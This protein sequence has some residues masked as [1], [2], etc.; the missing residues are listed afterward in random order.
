[1]RKREDVLKEMEQLGIMGDCRVIEIDH[2]LNVVV[3]RAMGDHQCSVV[4]IDEFV[5]YFTDEG[6]V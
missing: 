3:F 5:S 6:Y 4:S 1:M 2:E